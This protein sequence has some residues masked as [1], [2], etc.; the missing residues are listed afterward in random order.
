MG[1]IHASDRR[2]LFSS[3]RALLQLV[4]DLCLTAEAG[5]RSQANICGICTW[6][7]VIET[8]SYISFSVFA[9]SIVSQSLHTAVSFICYQRCIILEILNLFK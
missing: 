6:R 4:S 2:S 7:G 3:G 1:G 5:V 9:V 8:G